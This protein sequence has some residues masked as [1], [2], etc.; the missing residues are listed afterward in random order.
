MTK[1]NRGE[2]VK[3][4]TFSELIMGFA[5]AALHYTGESIL[6]G[7]GKVEKNLQLAKHNIDIV[8]LLQTKTKGNL[9]NDEQKLIE[10]ILSDLEYKYNESLRS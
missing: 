6:E 5:S 2:E 7:K 9:D 3:K 1:A 4:V 8:K 10:S